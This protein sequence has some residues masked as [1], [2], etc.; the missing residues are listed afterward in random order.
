MRA[1]PSRAAGPKVRPLAP[2][3]L[4]DVIAIDATLS[5]RSRSAY[6]E[7]RLACAKRR[8]EHH[9]QFA[10]DE[11][12]ALVGYALA[13]LLQGEFGR[14]EPGLRLEV[15]GVKRGAQNRGV[16]TALIGALE[17]QARRRKADELR[18]AALWRDHALLRFL[19]THGWSL[20]ANL[21]LEC[22]LA[23]SALGSASEAP[24]AVPELERAPA[25][26]HDY[27]A[28]APNDFETLARDT[29]EVRTLAA[30]DLEDIVRIDRRLTGRERRAYLAARLDEALVEAAFKLSLLARFEGTGAGFLM[31][32]ADYGDFGRME[33]AAVIDTVGVDPN[34][35][36]RGV[37]RAMLSQ[38]FFNLRA[39]GIERVETEVGTGNADLFAFLA[40]AGFRPGER[41]AFVKRLA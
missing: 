9:V 11:D 3:D 23:D 35:A 24:V 38:L 19:D 32:S 6:F 18:T 21:V 14:A 37:G 13:R 41:L 10:V 29:A 15:I 16:G 8:P 1:K 25:D 26:R 4:A 33:P 5:A 27:G 31:A 17:A 39:L 12:G 30:G 40:S 22:R 36:H 7:R 2:R 34:F 20:A 28:A